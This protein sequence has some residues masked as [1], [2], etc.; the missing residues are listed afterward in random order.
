M[1]HCEY[2]GDPFTPKRS[3]QRFCSEPGK[4]CRQ[5]WHAENL[6]GPTG[7]IYNV[8]QRPN[9]GWSVVVHYPGG[10]LPKLARGDT[11]K[12]HSTKRPDA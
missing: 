11:I 7:I 9:G 8:Y 6:L 3:G 4:S 2:C 12:I 10:Q 1:K 5:K